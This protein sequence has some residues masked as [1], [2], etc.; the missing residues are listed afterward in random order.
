MLRKTQPPRY[1]IF[2][3]GYKPAKVN[4]NYGCDD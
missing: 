3:E 4:A 1:V 2:I